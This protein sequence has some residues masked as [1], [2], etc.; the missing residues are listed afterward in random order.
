MKRIDSANK[1]ADLW[2][3]GKH[4]F[5]GGNPATNTPAT[6]L[7]PDWFNGVQEEICRVIEWLGD[8]ALIPGSNSQ[9]ADSLV[10]YFV[11]RTDFAGEIGKVS[12]IPAVQANT[13]HLPAFGVEVL[14]VGAYA[15]LWSYA[16]ASGA[17][18]TDD[19]RNT[20]PG[21]FTYGAGGPGGTTFRVPNIPGLVIKSFHNGDGTFTTNVSVGIGEYMP[22]VVLAHTHTYLLGGTNINQIS[23]GAT[24]ASDGNRGTPTMNTGSTGGSENTVRSVVLFPQIR[25][26]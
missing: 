18:V 7:T 24:D 8:R 10:A 6:F 22:D 19:L 2:G 23:G 17:L 1:A 26:R 21:C 9:L 4:G 15:Q 13:N 12:Y 11:A 5:S 14:R 25:Y 20:R 16:Q 3:P